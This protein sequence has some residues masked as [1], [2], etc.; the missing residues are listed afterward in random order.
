[1][2]TFMQTFIFWFIAGVFLVGW[3]VVCAFWNNTAMTSIVG[4]TLV[5]IV[6]LVLVGSIFGVMMGL[7]EVQQETIWNDGKCR[8][9]GEPVH[10]VNASR[11]KSIT[12]Y[13]Y[14]CDNCGNIIDVTTKF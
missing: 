12:H 11:Y 8:N 6:L 4:K 5:S 9:C 2:S 7:G 1:M 10:F 3:L 14:L 13:F